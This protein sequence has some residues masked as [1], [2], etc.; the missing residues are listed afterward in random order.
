MS[1]TNENLKA[2]FAGE[3]QANRKYLAFAKKAE[4]EGFPQIARLFR[5]A[6]EAETIHAH[7]HLRLLGAVKSTTE[8][9]QAAAEGE[10]YEAVSMYPDFIAQAE[11]EGDKKAITTFGWAM[12]AEKVHEQL[13]RDA[14]DSMNAEA[15]PFD[16][17]LCP[18]CG[19]VHARIAPEQCPI[20]GTR[21]SR[22]IRMQ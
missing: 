16:Y 7:S 17:Y 9:L 4:E 15:E 6:A 21:A 5:A 11:M 3:S 12:E 20:C 13:Y 1:K 18:V 10:H 22:F 2:A 8:N 14:L 19:Y